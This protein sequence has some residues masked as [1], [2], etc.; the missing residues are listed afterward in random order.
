MKDQ[1]SHAALSFQPAAAINTQVKHRHLGVDETFITAQQRHT[2]DTFVL[3]EIRPSLHTH[4]LTHTPVRFPLNFKVS[5]FSTR[6]NLPN[7]HHFLHPS[8]P[9][10]I[11]I[12]SRFHGEKIS[13]DPIKKNYLI[14][15]H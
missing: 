13:T 3:T 2:H 5:N 15:K 11:H 9:P 1:S 8:K 4:T 6:N 10:R 7:I 12:I 14:S